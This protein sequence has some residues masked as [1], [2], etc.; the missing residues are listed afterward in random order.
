MG[1]KMKMSAAFRGYRVSADGWAKMQRLAEAF[2][3]ASDAVDSVVGAAACAEVDEDEMESVHCRSM[4]RSALQE[5]H[6]WAQRSLAARLAACRP[7]MLVA[8]EEVDISGQ[9]QE[10]YGETPEEQ[11]ARAAVQRATRSEGRVSHVLVSQS[12]L[13]AMAARLGL[14]HATEE[15]LP[16]FT[17]HTSAGSITVHRDLKIAD[18]VAQLCREQELA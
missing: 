13:T 4:A 2:Q 16:F 9:A 7:S 8:V 5:A 1:D 17:M 18:G 14:C 11:I 3:F 15:P 10:F 6:L 12:T